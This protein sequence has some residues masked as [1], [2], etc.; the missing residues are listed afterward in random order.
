MA[1]YEVK[2]DMREFKEFID[3]FPEEMR[4]AVQ[5]TMM[6]TAR[7]AQTDIIDRAAIHMPG[8][9]GSF[10][11]TFRIEGPMEIEPG[12]FKVSLINYHE[13]AAAIEQGTAD[14]WNPKVMPIF[15]KRKGKLIFRHFR[16]GVGRGKEAPVQYPTGYR[17]F[18]STSRY[19]REFFFNR[20]S[21]WIR[22]RTK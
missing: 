1:V 12:T 21:S 14:Y 15:E 8:G 22:G 2:I 13:W 16:R 10:L 3:R 7:A 18:W 4:R 19:V 6:E 5:E 17:F 11:E 9:G 20:I